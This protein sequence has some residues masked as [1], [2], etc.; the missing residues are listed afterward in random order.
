MNSDLTNTNLFTTIGATVQDVTFTNWTQF[1]KSSN[2]LL[3][4]ELDFMLNLKQY[5]A[6]LTHN[7]HNITGNL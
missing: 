6:Q 5:T 7:P 1:S 4:L 2:E 3:V